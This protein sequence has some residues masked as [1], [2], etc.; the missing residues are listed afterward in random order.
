MIS[1]ILDLERE[2]GAKGM[3]DPKVIVNDKGQLQV[4]VHRHEVAWRWFSGY[5]VS[6]LWPANSCW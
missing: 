6:T 3:S 5:A 2:V 4:L 1:H